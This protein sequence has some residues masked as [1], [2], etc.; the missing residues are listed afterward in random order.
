MLPNYIQKK[1]KKQMLVRRIDWLNVLLI[2]FYGA[3][4]IRLFLFIVGI[5]L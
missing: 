4:F 5:D 1:G 2:V 3:M